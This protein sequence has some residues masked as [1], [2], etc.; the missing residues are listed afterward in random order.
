[1]GCF[2]VRRFR[3]TDSGAHPLCWFNFRQLP[4]GLSGRTSRTSPSR[5]AL[6]RLVQATMGPYNA[7]PRHA[8]I[9]FFGALA[10]LNPYTSSASRR[11]RHRTPTLMNR[12]TTSLQL[13]AWSRRYARCTPKRRRLPIPSNP[14]RC[15]NLPGKPSTSLSGFRLQ[16]PNNFCKHDGSSSASDS[17]CRDGNG[18]AL[19]HLRT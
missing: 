14:Q 10:L 13:L 6:A 4:Y 8:Q 2:G 16:L 15:N 12:S 19:M 11:S 9:V 3:V 17:C 18:I 7:L 1:M 5:D